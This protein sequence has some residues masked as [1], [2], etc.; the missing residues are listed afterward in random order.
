MRK[1]LRKDGIK[2]HLLYDSKFESAK[3]L[4]DYVELA[5]SLAG[6][7]TKWV[8]RL[9]LITDEMNNNAI[10]YGSKQK[11]KNKLNFE[12]I[13]NEKEIYI[14]VE[15]E[16]N[17]NG[18]SPKTAQEMESLR[19]EKGNKNFKTHQSIRGRGLFMIISSLVDNLYF[20]NNEK[21]GLIVGI[22]KTLFLT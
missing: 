7:D 13:K 6:I 18:K 14:K 20:K 22:E 9:I 3:I 17:G 5:S 4:R 19:N 2:L 16:D 12:I 21:G 10:E 8:S 1:F 11:E 15:V